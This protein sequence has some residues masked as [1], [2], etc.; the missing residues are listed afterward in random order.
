MWGGH[1]DD[2]DDDDD[3]DDDHLHSD[4]PQY[5]PQ[6][7]L[8]GGHPFHFNHGWCIS[9]IESV[10]TLKTKQVVKL[11]YCYVDVKLQL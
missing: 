7:L 1:D 10:I 11:L 9:N 3:D 2:N 6:T 5:L 8:Q 4:Y